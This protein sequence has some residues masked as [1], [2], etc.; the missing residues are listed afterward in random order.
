MQAKLINFKII[1]LTK[2][3]E[4][5]DIIK[6]CS[7]NCS[8]PKLELIF[9]KSPSQLEIGG[10]HLFGG[11]AREVLFFYILYMACIIIVMPLRH[12]FV[13]N[14]MPIVFI[15]IYIYIFIFYQLNHIWRSVSTVWL[16]RDRDDRIAAVDSEAWSNIND[17][18]IYDS[19]FWQHRNLYIFCRNDL[20]S[21]Q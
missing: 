17:W 12:S 2:Y 19:F 18:R 8:N 20:R 15:Y 21:T 14:S 10:E 4:T 9:S 16:L 1:M 11:T 6:R 7:S 3:C 13:F 5:Q